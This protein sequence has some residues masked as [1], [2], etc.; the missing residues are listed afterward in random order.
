[1]DAPH[2][3]HDAQAR[4]ALHADLAKFNFRVHQPD[5]PPLFTRSPTSTMQTVL[6][7][8]DDMQ[9]LLARLG[10]EIDLAPG[11]QRRTLRLHN[12][13][14]PFGTTPTFWASVQVNLPGEVATSRR[15]RSRRSGVEPDRRRVTRAQINLAS[16]CRK[17]EWP[18]Q[19]A[20]SV[21]SFW[22]ALCPSRPTA[23]VPASADCLRSTTGRFSARWTLLQIGCFALHQ[24]G[25][26]ASIC[27]AQ[28][29]HTAEQPLGVSGNRLA[30]HA[31]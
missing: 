2:T 20:S 6:W 7:R 19:G 13:G 28:R 10:A 17:L 8:G 18:L 12:P 16:F 30:P 11:G 4:R 9:A 22:A 3:M 25:L 21:V 1:M 5:D 31:G 26:N 29:G 14:L 24:S 27:Q 15:H 23:G